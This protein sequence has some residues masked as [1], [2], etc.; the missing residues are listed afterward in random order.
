MM[1]AMIMFI[2]ITGLLAKKYLIEVGNNT[3]E[4]GVDEGED[5][6]IG[7]EDYS[8]PQTI[9]MKEYGSSVHVSPSYPSFDI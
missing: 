6:R 8:A 3:G 2:L 9:Q 7:E 4:Q 5:G 1:R